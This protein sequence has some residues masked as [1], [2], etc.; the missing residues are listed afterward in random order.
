[1]LFYIL[2]NKNIRSVTPTTHLNTHSQHIIT[3]YSLI[4][5]NHCQV[6]YLSFFI[7]PTSSP[8]RCFPCFDGCHGNQQMSLATDGW[9]CV[10]CDWLIS[11]QSK[12]MFNLCC[13]KTDL[14]CPPPLLPPVSVKQ[15]HSSQ[16]L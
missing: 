13:P 10:G 8:S 9:K 4:Q 14:C 16:S 2:V 15:S 12:V 5:C 6:A 7:N 11:I 1:M 3:Q